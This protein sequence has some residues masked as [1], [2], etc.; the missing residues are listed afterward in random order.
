MQG[1]LP[2]RRDPSSLWAYSTCTSLNRLQSLI[3]ASLGAAGAWRRLG[4][5]ALGAL[6]RFLGKPG[7]EPQSQ[8]AV[9]PP[10]AL[11]RHSARRDPHRLAAWR[12]RLAG[13]A[14]ASTGPPGLRGKA[15][16]LGKA[17]KKGEV[18][19]FWC[20]GAKRNFSLNAFAVDV[21]LIV[22]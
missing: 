2:C 1:H 6:C 10:T 7:Q 9:A 21:T 14:R 5:G 11:R 12:P 16:S 3:A 22:I 8:P 19:S 18:A 17:K 4:R 15:W 13:G 20:F